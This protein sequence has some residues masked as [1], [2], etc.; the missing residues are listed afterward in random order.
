[1]TTVDKHN[2]RYQTNT[3]LKEKMFYSI[4]LQLVSFMVELNYRQ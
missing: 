2:D 4:V 3:F 1:L